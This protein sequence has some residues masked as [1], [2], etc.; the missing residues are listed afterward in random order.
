MWVV[1]DTKG[2]YDIA[3]VIWVK[4]VPK[5][6]KYWDEANEKYGDYFAEKVF[7]IYLQ[8]SS[9]PLSYLLGE[10]YSKSDRDRYELKVGGGIGEIDWVDYQILD[11]L[12]DNARIPLI[13]LA[14]KIK[15]S[16]Q[17]VSYRI[18]KLLKNGVLQGFKLGLNSKK[19]GLE[20]FKVDIWLK[21]PSKRS[22]IWNYI[23]YNPYITFLNTSAGYSD[24]GIEFNIESID[25]IIAIIDDV[26][27]QFPGAIR[28]YTYFG[29]QSKPYKIRCIPEMTE[30]DFKKN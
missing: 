6:Y 18:D 25:K 28:K 30:A 15:C 17:N 8:A 16:S 26:S 4:N 3:L 5:F 23:K 9:F 24:I 12:A 22:K 13:E 2:I 27:S 1:N 7:S 11:I 14:E 20:H 21:E 10:D 29:G 19:I